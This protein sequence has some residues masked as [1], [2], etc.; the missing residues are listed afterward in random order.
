MKR[1]AVIMVML[2]LVFS[3]LTASASEPA[4]TAAQWLEKGK[5]IS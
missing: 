2:V 5:E 3:A 4:L 1:L